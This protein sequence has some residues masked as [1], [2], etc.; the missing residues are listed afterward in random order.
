MPLSLHATAYKVFIDTHRKPLYSA[1]FTCIQ[2]LHSM[3]QSCIQP[4]PSCH[5]LDAVVARL[6]VTIVARTVS[7]AII[8]AAAGR[9]IRVLGALVVA[10]TFLDT[11]VSFLAVP[12]VASTISKAVIAAA[13]GRAIR[14]LGALVVTGFDTIVSILFVPRFAS[15]IIYCIVAVAPGRAIRILGATVGVGARNSASRGDESA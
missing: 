10:C 1:S 9:A 12:S 4:F 3:M 15:T 6:R 14:V 5:F 7:K 11:I 13:A 2:V 8:A